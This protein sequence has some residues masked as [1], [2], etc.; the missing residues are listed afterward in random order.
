MNNKISA[1]D[2]YIIE[3]EKMKAN[4]PYP[5][6]LTNLRG[7]AELVD[8]IKALRSQLTQAQEAVESARKSIHTIWEWASN[9]PSEMLLQDIR[10]KCKDVFAQLSAHTEEAK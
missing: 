10:G 4:T 8:E 3:F 6:E 5:I 2:D 9:S 1:I 7:A